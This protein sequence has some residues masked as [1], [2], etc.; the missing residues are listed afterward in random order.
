MRWS[1]I[2]APATTLDDLL[3]IEEGKI[4]DN[5]LYRSLDR[6]LRYK[7]QLETHL[8]DRYGALFG[9]EFDVLL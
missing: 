9:A 4:N 3:G 2:A 1:R 5:R 8:K 6:I 7:K